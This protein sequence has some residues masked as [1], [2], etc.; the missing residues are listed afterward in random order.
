MNKVI[1]FLGLVVVAFGL[2]MLYKT[3]QEGTLL[4]SVGDS[5]SPISESNL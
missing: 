5:V 1:A 4:E 2:L 3:G